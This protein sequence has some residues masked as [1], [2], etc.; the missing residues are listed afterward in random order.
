MNV[1]AGLFLGWTLFE[2][3]KLVESADALA[4]TRRLASG[5][6]L[7]AF[8][9]ATIMMTECRVFA[10]QG[11]LDRGLRVAEE[12]LELAQR[13]HN[14][15][16][17]WLLVMG[18]I[19]GLCGHWQEASAAFES[20]LTVVRESGVSV[21]QE[22]RILLHLARAQL[23]LGQGSQAVATAKEAIAVARTRGARHHEAYAH[24]VHADSLLA[25]TG[26]ERLDEIEQAHSHAEQLIAETGAALIAPNLCESRAAL[27]RLR[28]DD[29]AHQHHLREAH[30]LYTEMG[31]MGQRSEWGGS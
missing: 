12:M 8:A 6:T 13:S 7:G 1:T 4:T 27:A 17:V 25:T 29:T 14:V 19:Q 9:E 30:R 20:S 11:D 22:A 5:L 2:A 15:D 3:G 28:G 10:H 26:I 24:I 31:A 18:E 23:G 16:P 21:N